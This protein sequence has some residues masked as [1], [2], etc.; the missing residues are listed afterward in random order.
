MATLTAPTR[1]HAPMLAPPKLTTRAP[2]TMRR[3]MTGACAQRPARRRRRVVSSRARRALPTSRRRR[4]LLHKLGAPPLGARGTIR[5]WE[6]QGT[7]P[8]VPPPGRTMLRRRQGWWQPSW[9]AH[10]TLRLPSPLRC[11]CA[12]RAAAPAAR[13]VRSS[14]VCARCSCGS[15][16]MGSAGLILR[17][18]P[19]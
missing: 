17:R 13:S 9:R 11:R 12:R 14:A 3:P 2:Q 1:A 6:V 4:R 7:P 19:L 18:V 15:R 5:S 10:S 8:Q 16:M